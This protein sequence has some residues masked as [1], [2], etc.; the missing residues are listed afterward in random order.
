MDKGYPSHRTG[1]RIDR[2]TSCQTETET[3]YHS[4]NLELKDHKITD[5]VSLSVL[6]KNQIQ[7]KG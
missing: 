4:F 3:T 5:D 7:P 1:G 6:A 2:S